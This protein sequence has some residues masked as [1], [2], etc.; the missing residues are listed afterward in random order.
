LPVGVQ[1]QDILSNVHKFKRDL[2]F[3]KDINKIG[4][5]RIYI[6]IYIYIYKY[7]NEK[8][9][10]LISLINSADLFKFTISINLSFS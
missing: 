3:Y 6:Y 10:C 4:S 5:L 8:S 7:R 2:I 9:D 1:L